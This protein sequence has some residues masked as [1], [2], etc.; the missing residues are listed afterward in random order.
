M[1]VAWKVADNNIDLDR[2][3]ERVVDAVVYL[4]MASGYA[5]IALMAFHVDRSAGA[6]F[7]ISSFVAGVVLVTLTDRAAARQ[8]APS[9]IPASGSPARSDQP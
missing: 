7:L 3:G 9:E 5:G 1:I 8:K 2:L 6:V 4:S